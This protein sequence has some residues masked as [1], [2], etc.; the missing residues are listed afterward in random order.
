MTPAWTVTRLAPLPRRVICGLKLVLWRN[1]GRFLVARPRHRKELHMTE[2]LVT[3]QIFVEARTPQEAARAA[4]AAQRNLE[5]QATCFDV[6]DEAGHREVV[7]LTPE[8]AAIPAEP[9][10]VRRHLTLVKTSHA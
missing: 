8:S 5:S 6:R 4:L 2:Y 3:W 9:L 7:C 1:I 10:P